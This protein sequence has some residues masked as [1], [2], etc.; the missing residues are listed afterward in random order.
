MPNI[1]IQATLKKPWGRILPFDPF[2]EAE[3]VLKSFTKT[4]EYTFLALKTKNRSLAEKRP[5]RQH[6]IYYEIPNL[7]PETYVDSILLMRGL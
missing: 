3:F 5:N 6:T 1:T 7:P 4:N 2:Q